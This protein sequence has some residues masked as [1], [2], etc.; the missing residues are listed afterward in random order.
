MVAQGL[1]VLVKALADQAATGAIFQM[2]IGQMSAGR[3]PRKVAILKR[4]ADLMRRNALDD[5]LRKF[6]EDFLGKAI[7]DRLVQVAEF[8]VQAAELFG[9]RGRNRLH[10]KFTD[11]IRRH[12]LTGPRIAIRYLGRNHGD[13]LRGGQDRT[14]TIITEKEFEKRGTRKNPF[15]GGHDPP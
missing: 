10:E 11:R 5:D 1:D 12:A 15:Q 2:Q 14:A 6:G 8:Q 13:G 9:K 3:R 7:P 4:L